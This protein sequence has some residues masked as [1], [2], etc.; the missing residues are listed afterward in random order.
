MRKKFKDISEEE[1]DAICEKNKGIC[2]KCPFR[3]LSCCAR[4]YCKPED[5]EKEIKL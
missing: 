1:Q 5:L 2:K 4:E 3:V